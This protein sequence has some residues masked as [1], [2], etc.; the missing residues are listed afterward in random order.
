MSKKKEEISE[1]IHLP[2]GCWMDGDWVYIPLPSVTLHIPIDE[3]FEYAKMFK[4]VDF[5]LKKMLREEGRE[6]LN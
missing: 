2:K 4:K 3:F 1:L 5:V 6:L